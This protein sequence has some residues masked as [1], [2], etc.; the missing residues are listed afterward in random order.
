[1][2]QRV[3]ILLTALGLFGVACSS[4]TNLP[5]PAADA[6][7]DTEPAADAPVVSDV[8]APSDRLVAADVRAVDAPA[9]ACRASFDCPAGNYCN[10]GSC[11]P[12]VCVPGSATCVTATTRNLCNQIGS[13][14]T[15]VTCTPAPHAPV[16]GCMAGNCMTACDRAWG[17]CDGNSSNGCEA[18]LTTAARCGACGRACADGQTCTDG[19]CS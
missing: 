13:A 17:D 3:C 19:A 18:S 14:A 1:M 11:A 16:V 5:P 2:S 4:E 6:A 7:A 15:V 10:M 12:R 9:A 8:T